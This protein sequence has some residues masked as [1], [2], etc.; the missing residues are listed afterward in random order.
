MPYGKRPS[1]CYLLA[2]SDM[3]GAIWPTFL[4]TVDRENI[5]GVIFEPHAEPQLDQLCHC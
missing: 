5:V 2:L 1:V 4:D 3:V